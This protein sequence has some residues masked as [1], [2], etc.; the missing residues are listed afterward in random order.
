M[1]KIMFRD[2]YNLLCVANV[3]FA[4]YRQSVTYMDKSGAV[5]EGDGLLTF[6]EETDEDMMFFPSD[7]VAT[8]EELLRSLFMNDAVDLTDTG[9]VC[10]FTDDADKEAMSSLLS[11]GDVCNI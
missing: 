6:N 10:H 2:E 1:M 9:L 5:L 11:G 3:S 7:D 8:C 4:A